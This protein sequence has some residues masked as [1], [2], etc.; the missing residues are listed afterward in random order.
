MPL[1]VWRTDEVTPLTRHPNDPSLPTG[2]GA[3]AASVPRSGDREFLT[4]FALSVPAGTPTATVDTATAH[5]AERTQQLA[6]QGH[7]LRLWTLPGEGQALGLWRA[8][9]EA[10]MASILASLPLDAWLEVHTTPLTPHPSDPAG[11]TSGFGEGS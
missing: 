3:S 10:E 9:D 11:V 1:R 6:R 8:H 5:E 4:T 2:A 7:L